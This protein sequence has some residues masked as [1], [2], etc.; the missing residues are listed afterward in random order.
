MNFFLHLFLLLPFYF[1]LS[2]KFGVYE[3]IAFKPEPKVK[4]RSA[5][6]KLAK[7]LSAAPSS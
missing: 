7:G 3:T 6:F 2:F 5:G 4:T 1:F